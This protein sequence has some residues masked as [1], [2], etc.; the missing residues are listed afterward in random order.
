MAIAVN[1][2]PVFTPGMSTNMLTI[3]A[4]T[5]PRSDR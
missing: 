4:T 3:G 5:R 1:V 2:H